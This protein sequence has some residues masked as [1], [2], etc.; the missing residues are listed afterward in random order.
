MTNADIEILIDDELGIIEVKFASDKQYLLRRL[1]RATKQIY[2]RFE[3]SDEYKKGVAFS[4]YVNEDTGHFEYIYRVITPETQDKALDQLPLTNYL[5]GKAREQGVNVGN[6]NQPMS[7]TFT[8]FSA[9]QIMVSDLQYG[10]QQMVG[11]RQSRQQ[12]QWIKTIDDTT[13][14]NN[15]SDSNKKDT[16]GTGSRQ[17]SLTHSQS[18]QQGA[19]NQS[20]EPTT[21]VKQQGQGSKITNIDPKKASVDE[22]SKTL[23]ARDDWQQTMFERRESSGK[24]MTQQRQQQGNKTTDANS[25][26][27][28]EDNSGRTPRTHNEEPQTKYEDKKGVR[29]DLGQQR[30]RQG[31]RAKQQGDNIAKKDAESS[32]KNGK[33]GSQQTLNRGSENAKDSNRPAPSNGSKGAKDQD[34][35]NRAPSHGGRSI[36][37]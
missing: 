14:I 30:Q 9:N 6:Q 7:Q 3:Q 11:T 12:Q 1:S 26:A 18:K 20:S 28:S 2:D 25:K 4:I 37:I 29:E 17:W 8:G 10:Y 36:P 19:S 15:I 16:A 27:A 5:T 32:D 13:T 34:T 35:K 21:K 33:S 31:Q 24:P 22:S 23:K